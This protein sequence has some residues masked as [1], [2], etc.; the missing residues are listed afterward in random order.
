MKWI[1]IM[2]IEE[3]EIKFINDADWGMT[4]ND[5]IV[6]NDNNNNNKKD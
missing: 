4:F 2:V 5:Y 3:I 1:T 6:F